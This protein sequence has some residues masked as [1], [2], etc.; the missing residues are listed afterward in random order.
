MF[1]LIHY[2]FCPFSRSI[3]LALAECGLVVE[4]EEERP[5]AWRR[6]FLAINPAGTLPVLVERGGMVLAGAYPISEYLAETQAKTN[7][8]GAPGNLLFPGNPVEKAEIRRVVDWFH[9]KFYEEVSR[10]LLDERL[11][12]RFS[13][14]GRSSPD[15]SFIRAGRANLR[16]HLSYINHLAEMRTWLAGD[17]PSFADLAAGGHLS[18]LDYL[19]E[20]PWGDFPKARAWYVQIKARSSFRPLLTDRLPGL[21]PAGADAGAEI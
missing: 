7:G 1:R 13:D 14:T 12:Q 5:W 17:V 2:P 3:R 8:D 11:Y 10:Y 18:V 20:V 15:T 19:G 6:D 4:L 16:Y 9:C 21:A